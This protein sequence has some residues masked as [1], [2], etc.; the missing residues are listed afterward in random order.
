M[1]IGLLLFAPAI[2]IGWSVVRA[3]VTAPFT[4]PRRLGW[5]GAL[6]EIALGTGVG[7]GIVSIVFFALLWAGVTGRAV[8]LAAEAVMAACGVWLAIRRPAAKSEPGP[9]AQPPLLTK[10]SGW[11][12]LLRAAA[13]LVVLFFAL[14]AA[15]SIEADPHGGW[16]AFTIWNVK[17][18]YLAG[19]PLTWRNVLSPVAG[20]RAALFG[21]NHPG[22]PLLLPSAVAS[23][24]SMQGETASF[25][26]GALSLLFAFATAAMLGGAVAWMRG[27]AA[28]LLALLLLLAS[29]GFASQAGSQNADI[30]LSLYLLATLALIALAVD[31]G[32]PSGTLLLAGLCCGLAA[33]TKNEGLPF[34]ILAV[35]AV[36]WNGGRKAAVWMALGAV[37]AVALL[38]A[39]KILLVHDTEGLFPKTLGQALADA[40]NVSRWMKIAGSFMQSIWRMGTPWAHPVLLVAILAAALGLAPRTRVRQQMWLAIPVVGLLAADFLIYLI[41]AADLTWQLSTSNLRL[42]VQV[43]PALLLL[44]FLVIAPPALPAASALEAP[45]A[46]HGKADRKQSKGSRAVHAK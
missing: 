30:P 23:A 37:P 13:V 16:D 22:Y 6:L 8:L 25:T 24:W 1:L 20:P 5:M 44:A 34:A 29:E 28:G 39:F 40:A 10:T 19:G 17:A 36:A 2:L 7:I 3:L 9:A 4:P 35:A 31:R 27:E 21:A 12:W 15:R 32:W 11:I 33:W 45:R 14:D 42:I 41:T 46:A 38:A 43:W 26:P 18:K